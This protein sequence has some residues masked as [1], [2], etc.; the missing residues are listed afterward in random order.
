MRLDDKLNAAR[1]E[2]FVNAFDVVDLVVNNRSRMIE[3]GPISG[4]HHQTKPATIEER[5]T[6]RRLKQKLHPE[7]VAIKRDRAIQV[8]D[9]NVNLSDLRKAGPDRNWRAHENSPL[10]T[11]LLFV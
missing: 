9:V 6:G 2:G 11:E 7:H 10:V 1:F 5:H 8:F 4:T 3:V